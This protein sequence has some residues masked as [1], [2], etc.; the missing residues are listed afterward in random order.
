MQ[1]L[2]SKEQP[3][4]NDPVTNGVLRR[5]AARIRENRLLFILSFLLVLAVAALIVVSTDDGDSEAIA[6]QDEARRLLQ[7]DRPQEALDLLAGHPEA[8]L[9]EGHYL[10]AVALD[11]LK[12]KDAAL[13]AI[14]TATAAAPEN[15]KYRGLELRLQLF[16][17]TGPFADEIL[18]LYSQNPSSAALALFAFYAHQAR[19]LQL[20]SESKAAE[21]NAEHGRSL[22]ALQTAATLAAEIPEFQRELLT[23]AMQFGQAESARSLVDRLLALD[24]GNEDFLKHKIAVLLMQKKPAEALDAARALYEQSGRSE[25]AAL[26]YSAV[27]DRI[28]IQKERVAE[29]RELAAA[30]PE[31]LVLIQRLA[32]YLARAGHVA[33]A[34]DVLAE[35]LKHVSD[36]EER[37]DLVNSAVYIPLEAGH[38]ELAERQLE[39]YRSDIREEALLDYFQGRLL[40]L[41]GQPDAAI[42]KLSQ[43][44]VRN[45]DESGSRSLATEAAIWAQKIKA[46]QAETAAKGN[47]SRRPVSP[48]RPPTRGFP[49]VEK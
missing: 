8:I 49:A 14:R 42:A 34:C 19:R 45:A 40:Y 10:K 22:P 31:N 30:H 24:P 12:M 18:D 48:E 44:A 1:A 32:S 43:V 21:A 47:P 41:K 29:L 46:E 37:W 26:T 16:E 25:Q 11:R 13:A 23:F 4:T 9:S 36:Q 3:E 7:I 33:E 5:L 15:S 39:R 38:A 17:T 27:L 2:E 20:T 28:S 35:S 6:I